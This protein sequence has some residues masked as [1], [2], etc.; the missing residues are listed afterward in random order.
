MN[1]QNYHDVVKKMVQSIDATLDKSVVGDYNYRLALE[2]KANIQRFLPGTDIDHEAFFRDALINRDW[3]VTDEDHDYILEDT[4]IRGDETFLQPGAGPVIF[5]TFHLGSYRLLNFLLARRGVDFSLVI[6]DTAVTL[7]AGKFKN[8]FEKIERSSEFPGKFSILNA[9]KQNIG[10]NMIRTLR[11]NSSLV[12]YLDGNSGVGGMERRDEKLLSVKFLGG[13]ILARKGISYISYRTKIPIVPVYSFREGTHNVM[14]V[15]PA[16]YPDASQ[17]SDDY[18][19]ATTQVLYD[20]LAQHLRSRP[21]QWEGWLYMQKFADFDQAPEVKDLP[22]TDE[23]SFNQ[24]RF[25]IYQ[26]SDEKGVLFDRHNYS[27]FPISKGLYKVLD[28]T[29]KEGRLHYQ[30]KTNLLNDLYRR[31]VLI[32]A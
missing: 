5:C 3:A 24:Q 1:K 18:C 10:I 4:E 9:E 6:D 28:H 19:Q 7:Q 16:I 22:T 20:H 23:L 17:A 26:S 8:M 21:T 15:L 13:R 30:I 27:Y 11:G 25:D 2:C 32:A 29:I 14:E 31:S 12:L